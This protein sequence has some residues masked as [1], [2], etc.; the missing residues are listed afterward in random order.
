MPR[1]KRERHRRKPTPYAIFVKETYPKYRHLETPQ[2]RIRAIAAD[3][4]EGGGPAAGAS[5]AGAAIAASACEAARS[6]GCS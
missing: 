3:W 6:S 2:E 4:L 1:K 5:A